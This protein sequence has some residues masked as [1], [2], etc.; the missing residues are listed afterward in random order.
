MGPPASGRAPVR[1]DANGTG[2]AP[3]ARPG[4]G[5]GADHPLTDWDRV[6]ASVEAEG[7]DRQQRPYADDP[8]EVIG[9]F[10][11]GRWT[12]DAGAP[13]ERTR[14]RPPAPARPGSGRQAAAD[15]PTGPGRP[16]AGD[17]PVGPGRTAAGEHRSGSHRGW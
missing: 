3:T 15:H 2:A 17:H 6:I 9:P 13:S 5:E 12:K 7:L 16:V 1:P 14:G 4:S 11:I 10:D 8:T